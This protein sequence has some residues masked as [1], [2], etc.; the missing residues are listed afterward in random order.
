M[1][2]RKAKRSKMGVREPERRVFPTHRAFVRR[3]RCC[4][5]GCAGA[6][7]EFAHAKTRG[8]GGHDAQGVSLCLAHHREQH[9]IGIETFQARY[10][11]DLFAIAARFAATTTDKALR[12][13]LRAKE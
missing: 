7:I 8:S 9:T 1:L 10:G 6:P 12:E 5:P 13:A 3:H 4:V 11:I 2:P